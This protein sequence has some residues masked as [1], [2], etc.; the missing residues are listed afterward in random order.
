[1]GRYNIMLVTHQKF[2]TQIDQVFDQ[3]GIRDHMSAC[4][5]KRVV[6]FFVSQDLRY[7]YWDL[8]G[9]IRFKYVMLGIRVARV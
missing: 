1:M 7:I 8:V 2:R 5:R 9:I 3:S 4:L 6:E